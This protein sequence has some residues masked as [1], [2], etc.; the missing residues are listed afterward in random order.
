M[1]ESGLESL[2]NV[3]GR[4]DLKREDEGEW[5]EPIPDDGKMGPNQVEVLRSLLVDADGNGLKRVKVRGRSTK[6]YEQAERDINRQLIRLSSKKRADMQ[7]GVL[8]GL[9]ADH[10]VMDWEFTDRHGNEIPCSKETIRAVLEDRELRNHRALIYL[11]I[12][13][14]EEDASAVA[15]E[16]LGN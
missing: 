2:R 1:S 3:A 6:D 7:R 14:L 15:E 16:D 13:A 12:Q 9:T 10:C 8:D 5:F 11:A 4:V